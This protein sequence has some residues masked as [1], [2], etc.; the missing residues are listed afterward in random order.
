MYHYFTKIIFK[1]KK[2]KTVCISGLPFPLFVTSTINSIHH[3]IRYE[4]VE[5]PF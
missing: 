4:A 3:P 5:T 2:G 1:N